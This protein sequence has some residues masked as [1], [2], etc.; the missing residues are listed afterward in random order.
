[1]ALGAWSTKVTLYG[2]GYSLLSSGDLAEQLE[3]A[4]ERLPEFPTLHILPFPELA[5]E[6]PANVQ[7]EEGSFWVRA[8]RALCQVVD[9]QAQQV[10]YGGR[11]LTADDTLTGRRLAA[12][13][14]LRDR[15][16]RVLK[17]QND[18]WPETERL[19]ARDE[20][21]RAYDRF[22][23]A[24]GPINKTTFGE[25]RD[26]NVSRR[27]PYLVKFREDPDAMLVM[28]LEDYDELTGKAAKAAILLQDVVGR[29]PPLTHVASAQ[30]GPSWPRRNE[31]VLPMPGTSRH[32]KPCSPKMCCRAI[33][34]PS[35]AP[36]GS[37]QATLRPL[38][39]KCLA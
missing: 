9:G 18:D 33:S 16:R 27:M 39:R 22:V 2:E 36:P 30:E 25:T 19:E 8:D 20:I 31:L 1:M 10:V 15:A 37:R 38:P 5:G 21:N 32:C 28:S 6:R 24:Y 35:S 23:L 3:R 13:V 29:T 34:T 4:I 14:G 17:S 7:L 12:L 26:G 11:K